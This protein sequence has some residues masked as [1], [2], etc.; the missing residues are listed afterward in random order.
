MSS[1]WFLS[2]GFSSQ[3]ANSH[4][5]SPH[6]C[7]IPSSPS[8]LICHGK[9]TW[10]RADI[11]KLLNRH[12]LQLPVIFS[13]LGPNILLKHSVSENPQ[14]VFSWREERTST[15]IGN[16]RQTYGSLRSTFKFLD[17]RGEYTK[18]V[19]RIFWTQSVLKLRNILISH[20]NYMKIYCVIYMLLPRRK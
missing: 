16:S 7:Y 2:I 5:S 20:T 1:A 6:A 15:L 8:S 12:S 17:S 13:L 11:L 14:P 18:T 4:F 10:R 9:H 3:K 19:A